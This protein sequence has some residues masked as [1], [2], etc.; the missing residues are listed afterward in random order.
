MAQ[1]TNLNVTPYYDDFDKTKNFY[2][3]LFRPG[4]P[5]QARELTTLQSTMQNQVEN[6]GSH[7]FKDGA[8]VIPGQIGYDLE[9]DAIMLQE[10]FLGADVELYRTQLENKIITGLTSGVKA[11]VL[12]TVSETI[13]EKGYITLYV[14]YIE[15][16][17]TT[18]TQTTFTNNEQLVTDTEITFGT[19]LIEIGSP[20]AQLLPTAAIQTGSAAYIQPGVYFIRGFF[21]DVPYQYILL[22]QYGTTPAYRIGLEILE[23]IVTPEDDLSL[24]DNAAGTSNYAAPGSHRFRITTNL[25]KKL[26]TDE[27]DKDF[28]EL[29]RINGTKV[30]KLVDRSAYDEL[31]KSMALRTFEESGNYV[32]NDF[33]ITNRENLN[34]G[35]NNGVYN[36]GDTTAQGNSATNQKYAV[37]FGPGTA[38]V[39]GYRIKTLSPTYV[40]VDKPRSTNNAQN[41]IIPFELGNYSNIQNVYGFLNC[42]GSTITNAYQTLELKDTFT[43]TPGTA[44]GNVIGYARVSSI[45]H[46]QDPDTTFGN[47]DDRYRL[48][49]FDVQMFTQLQLASS[50]SI[51]AGSLVIGK[52]SGARGYVVDAV[53]SDPDVTLYAVEG[54]FQD[55]EMITVDGLDK[56][57]IS[58]NYV[59]EY[60][61]TRQVVSKDESTSAVEFTADVVLEDLQQLQGAT[62]TYDA[63]GSAEKIT[64]TNSNISIDLRA[65]DRIYFSATKYV[66][67]DAI[68][69]T[70]LGSSNNGTIFNYASQ[71]V[72]VTPGAG[73]AAPSAGDYTVL[74]RY[75]AKLFDQLSA[76]LLEQMPRPYV[77]S[78]ADESMIV[79]R[80]FDSQ[81]VAS[82]SIAITLPAN[83]QFEALSNS[84]YTFTVL[85]STNGTYP[86]GDQIPIDTTNTG[87]LGYTTFTSSDRTTLQMDNLTNITSVKVTASIS[88]NVTTKKTK[89]PQ[90]MFVLKTNK[91]INNLDKQNYNL[92]Y[93]N[94]YGTRIEDQDLSLGLV[95]AYKIHAVY[96]SLDDSDPIL[97]SITLVEPTFFATGSIVTGRTSKA[98]ARVVDF[99]SSTLKLTIVYLSGQFI[100]GETVD[101]FDSTPTAI[102]GI[103][104]DSAG[105]IIVGSKV[106]TDRYDLESGQTNFLY[107]IS[108]LVR[109]TGVSRP[110]R[111]LKVVLDYY[112]H[113]ATGDYFGGQS[114]L[115]TNYEDVPLFDGLFLPDYLDFRP[116]VKNLFSGT[117]TVSS[118]AFVNCSTFDF[119]SRVFPTSSTP[120][121]TLFDVPKVNSD[122]RCDFDWYLPRIDKV[123]L[124]PTGEFQIIKGKS[125]ERP[126]APDD[127][128]DGMLLATL[129]HAPYGFDPVDDVI[130]QKSENRRYT[131]RDIGK[132]ETRLNQVEYYTSLNMLESD[133]F[134]TDITDASGKSRLKNGFI[135]DDFTDHSKSDTSNPDYSASLDYAEGSAHPSHFTTNIS[136]IINTSLSTN[137][138]KTGPLITLPYTEE[139]LIEQPYASRVENVNPFNVFAYI[140]R[141]DL[142]P[143]SDDWVDTNRL[144]VRVTNIEG[145]FQSTRDSMNVDQNGFAPIQW[146]SWRTTWT[147]ESSSGWSR[148]REHT[149]A[150]FVA[151]RGRR[152]MGTR[153]ITSTSNQTRQGI[154]T[155]VV[156]RIDRRSLGD[157]TVSSTSIP[158]IRSRNIDVTV[159][160]MKPRTTFYG[161]FDGTK[162]GDYMIPKVLEV[163]KDP[164]TDSRT[165]STP[166]VIGETVVGQT[167]G[168]TLRIAAPNDFYDFNPYTDVAMPTSY[169]STT[170]FVNLDT[171]S[172]AAQAVGQYFGN[173]QVGELLVAASGATAVVKDRRLLTDRL[174]QWKGSL[175]IP[176]PSIDTNPRWATGTRTLRFTTNENDSRVGGTVAS[177]AEVEY[178]AEGTLNTLQENVLSIRNADVVRDTV[179]QDR[180]INSTRTES[181]QVGWWDPLAQS[182]LVTETGGTFLTSVEIYFN[183]KDSN[184]PISMQIRTME[185][186]Y[187]TTAILP[188]SDVTINPADVQISE[189]GAVAT[190][191]TFQAPVYIPQSIEHCFVLFSDSNEYQVWIS[192]MGELDIS[193]DRTI[194]EQP[195]AGVLFK[196]QNATTWTA[197]QYEDLKFIVNRASFDNS[198]ATRITLNNAPLDRGNN[199]KITLQN[200]AIQTFQPELQLV[201]NSTTLPFTI[202]A[203]VYQKTTLAEGTIV[204]IGTSSSGVLLT[205]NDI[206]GT[207]Q[208]GSNTGGVIT[209]RVVSS[210][211]TATMV[212]SG[213]SGDFV[214]GETI[215]GNSSTTPTAEVVTWTAGTNTLTLRYVSTDFTAST[216]TVTGAGG[217]TATVSS[218]TYAGDVIEGGAVSDAYVGTAPTYTTTQRKV[219]VS[220]SSHCMHDL[221][222]NVVITG[223]ISEVS[224]TYLTSSISATDTTI[225]INDASAFHKI[226]NG[227]AISASNVGYIKIGAEVMSYSAIASNGKSITVHERGVDGSTGVAHADESVVKC[228]NIDGIPLPEINKTHAA[229]QS[230][231]LDTYDLATTSIARLGIRSGGDGIV[232]TQ[233]I[234]YEILVPQI[235]KMLLPKT[236]VT[237]RV[238]TITGSSI[239]DG[240]T[241]SQSSF[242]NTGEFSD[243]N[244]SEDNYF[245]S[246]QLICSAINESAELSGDKSFRMDLTLSS[247]SATV[248]PVMDTDRMSITM[249]SSRINNPSDAN[250]AKRP[251]GDEHS[252]IYISKVADLVNPSSAIKLIFAG[253]R[254]PNTVIKPLYRV[255]PSGSTDPIETQG[256][257]FFPTTGATIPGTTE[258]EE[259]KDYEYEVS[260]LSFSQYQI[261]IVFVSPNQAYS[262]VIKDF[263]A[264]ALAV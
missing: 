104:N 40:D 199:G 183:A 250:V 229:I 128:Q 17:G 44:A 1:N 225:N 93:S 261:K 73:G 125:E 8:M 18:Q 227:A 66:D 46:V 134:N 132:I 42:S 12:F 257:E 189:T 164:S 133:T 161:F 109:K 139:K 79:R 116:G 155:R 202:G 176:Q 82:S 7:L 115:D 255:L 88:K 52:T 185:N 159:A 6:V 127:L 119:K 37:E 83:E 157:S 203:R 114:Y 177:A 56:D 232:A 65:G 156:P 11:K 175:F 62:F 236:D 49:I 217:T 215:T 210:K 237:A 25:I 152:V 201:M 47:A 107:G 192:R 221:D 124:L 118:P 21:V 181:R 194:S 228:Y 144:P 13:S 263:R 129:S 214:V 23:S 96:E 10:S 2:R 174:G 71:S 196:S 230:P 235:Q 168:A 258:L 99:N 179:S 61:D 59:Y 165:N 126:S 31:E 207:W 158:W 102:T 111:K 211:A 160:R 117:G 85:A 35:F 190:K 69:P 240:Q 226:I 57:T 138:R 72:N 222:N 169:S 19:T 148:R 38:Y 251:F 182:F 110:I 195:Y 4:F 112:A 30:E 248:S 3:V 259:Y 51:T 55:G 97:P 254:P 141:I 81:T 41:V 94:L 146:Q 198:G 188:F 75:R 145:D 92:A 206:S 14:K 233:N 100:V 213:A 32:V 153:T 197:D 106:I 171:D 245:N 130:I 86:V 249:V 264:I 241:L 204:G 101:G 224:D 247:Q 170:D 212:V 34:D 9:V 180:T 80:T 89:S 113:A 28:I 95:D 256:F 252:A 43:S 78:I 184:I 223:V 238:Q 150:N 151:G 162:V 239:N 123:F 166:F 68:D 167:S 91:T 15:S 246:P 135:V 64:G 216:E 178:K 187:P 87:A 253:Y 67:V 74:I 26:L 172:L 90:K 20:F 193:G 60:S 143:A 33:Q 186:G 220:H 120:A 262:P 108:R 205:I 137:Y 105:S 243:V 27:A 103:I 54:T 219:R 50:Q 29:L 142:V 45:E 76:S 191:F 5:I 260:G 122:F 24:N 53:S 77:K 121:A 154:R 136:L 84:N 231:S 209:N 63:T 22:D 200:D 98:R 234:Q 163:I 147:G 16:G 58:K 131:M 244:L 173:I 36:T 218:V 140:G 242:S 48:H 39:R 208:A 149:F 70:N